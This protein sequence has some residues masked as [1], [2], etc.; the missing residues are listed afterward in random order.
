[1]T[2]RTAGVL[3]GMGPAATI[4]FMAKVLVHSQG[5]R[6]PGGREQDDVRLIVDSNPAVPDRNAAV[7]GT[8]PSPAPFLADMARGLERAGVDFLVMPC[9]AAHAFADAVRAATP[10]PFV[11]LI[12]EAVAALRTRFPGV[13]RVGV[14]AVN[15]CADAR[16]YENAL[17]PAGIEAV[18]PQG[19]LRRRFMD[20]VWAI[21][22]GDKSRG[23]IEDMRLVA[24]ALIEQGASVIIAGC[25]EVPLLLADGDLDVPMLDSTDVLALRTVAYARGEAL[26]GQ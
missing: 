6:G 16:L 11:S 5:S 4:D 17:A 23:S 24:N 26:P 8:G 12:D 10:V 14:L 21:K 19:A 3:G 22:R 20:T 13:E 9:N 15:G 25:T 1:M 2:R 18:T 7:A